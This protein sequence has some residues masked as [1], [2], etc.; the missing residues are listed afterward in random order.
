MSRVRRWIVRR[1]GKV[2]WS[3]PTLPPWI[4]IN[5]NGTAPGPH[6]GLQP[7]DLSTAAAAVEFLEMDDD[8]EELSELLAE[9]PLDDVQGG[10][11]V[12]H[13]VRVGKAQVTLAVRAEGGA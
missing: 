2:V 12:L 13:R 1:R 7:G 9:L 10:L 3:E 5:P 6:E 4:K 11:D 8:E